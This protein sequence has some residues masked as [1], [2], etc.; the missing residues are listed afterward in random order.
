MP[1]RTYVASFSSLGREL[2]RW[3]IIRRTFLD[4]FGEILDS[5]SEMGERMMDA[6]E[7]GESD[8]E[9]RWNC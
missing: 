9:T 1:E 8:D 4:Y 3:W 7:Q 2:V 6:Q 5:T